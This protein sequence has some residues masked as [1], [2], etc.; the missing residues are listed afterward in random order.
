MTGTRD[1]GAAPRRP[2][3]VFVGSF[4]AAADGSEGGQLY[5]CRE[6]MRTPVAGAARWQLVD[7]TWKS[8]PLPSPPRRAMRALLRF[9]RTLM[10]LARPRTRS[11]LVFSRFAGGSL[12]EKGLLCIVARALGKRAVL[13]IQS[14]IPRPA[15][16]WRIGDA[17]GRLVAACCSSIV[18]QSSRAAEELERSFGASPAKLEIVPNWLDVS[19]YGAPGPAQRVA[20][21]DGPLLLFVGLLIRRKGCRELLE[22]SALLAQEGRA[23]RVDVYG[24]GPD[25]EALEH[26]SWK[27]GLEDRVRFRGWVPN[28][29]M[30]EIFRS[31]DAFVL[32]TH[33]EGLPN[34]LLEAMA[35]AL[36]VVT[37]PVNCIPSVVRS[38]KNG[39]LVPPRDVDALAGA[40]REILDDPA[41]RKEMGAHNREQIAR[42]HDVRRAWPRIARLLELD[43]RAPAAA[44]E[45][46]SVGAASD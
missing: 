34:A 42:E 38:R 23:F 26:L 28:E 37:T 8:F 3:V 22:A 44:A 18:C 27:L 12:L 45:P 14:G 21:D 31:A 30:P 17:F 35:S 24:S 43:D 15:G 29:E 6:L 40:L 10:L 4:A 16:A 36:P 5:A 7:T 2:S 41:V 32:P 33:S 46:L 19:R 13:S 25:R 11:I 20:T 9:L 39:L 1:R